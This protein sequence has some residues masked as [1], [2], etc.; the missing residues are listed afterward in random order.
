[1]TPAC[2]GHA[3]LF[4]RIADMIDDRETDTPEW[5]QATSTAKK[6][7]STCPIVRECRENAHINGDRCTWRA[8]RAIPVIGKTTLTARSNNELC[9]GCE[10]PLSRLRRC[11]EGFVPHKAKG[12]CNTCH[13]RSFREVRPLLRNPQ[14]EHGTPCADCQRPMVGRG[15]RKEKPE[16]WVQHHSRGA[17]KACSARRD[18][19]KAKQ[20]VA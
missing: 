19:A 15:K 5:Q 7:C 20:V 16:G 1:M 11:D 10:R 6:L 4:D 9:L 14:M 2:A 18:R 13:N 3:D 12:L 17:C 8:G